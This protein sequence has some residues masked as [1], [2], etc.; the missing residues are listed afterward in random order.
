M[1]SNPG[2]S[3][4]PFDLETV[5]PGLNDQKKMK[6]IN[7]M[8]HA[9]IDQ[10]I[11]I[12]DVERGLIDFPAWRAGQEVLLCY[13]LRDGDRIGFW[14]PLEGGYSGRQPIDELTE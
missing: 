10:G 7:G 4:V 11:V 12:Q 9:L 14:H 5:W 6:L 3:K 8:L 13:E 2:P 1:L